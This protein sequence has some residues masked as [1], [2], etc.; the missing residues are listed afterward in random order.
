[1]FFLPIQN[2]NSIRQKIHVYPVCIYI[3]VRCNTMT[4]VCS[5]VPLFHVNV[6]MDKIFEQGSVVV[7]ASELSIDPQRDGIVF[8]GTLL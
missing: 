6:E 1:M 5:S 2:I 7:N 3:L 4:S 8:S